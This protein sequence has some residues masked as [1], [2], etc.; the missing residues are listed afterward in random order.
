MTPEERHKRMMEA[1]TIEEMNQIAREYLKSQEAKTRKQE[2]IKN[3]YH[4]A[5]RKGRK[6]DR[7]IR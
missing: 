2:R 5:I 4:R 6:Y 1:S 7:G 3:M